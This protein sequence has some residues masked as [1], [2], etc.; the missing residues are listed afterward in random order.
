ML[1]FS[2]RLVAPQ[3]PFDHVSCV[4]VCMWGRLWVRRSTDVRA[5]LSRPPWLVT[6]DAHIMDATGSAQLQFPDLCECAA[7][8]ARVSRFEL[9]KWAG[10]VPN[11]ALSLGVPTR[12]A[13]PSKPL[14]VHKSNCTQ[15][16]ENNWRARALHGV[17]TAACLFRI[18]YSRV[19]SARTCAILAT[20]LRCTNKPSAPSSAQR[21]RRAVNENETCPP[22]PH[23]YRVDI[24]CR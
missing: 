11:G 6:S 10:C 13:I 1:S 12:N 24:V 15:P 4:I 23:E 22:V 3:I 16:K 14:L 19:V 7:V 9:Y 17:Y 21:Y 8:S 18:Y 20:V 5:T 2:V